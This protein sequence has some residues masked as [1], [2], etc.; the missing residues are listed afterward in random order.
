MTCDVGGNTRQKSEPKHRR[1]VYSQDSGLRSHLPCT[2]TGH[3]NEDGA[4]QRRLAHQ[5]R[6][7]QRLRQSAARRCVVGVAPSGEVVQAADGR[8]RVRSEKR[9]RL[10]MHGDNMGKKARQLWPFLRATHDALTASVSH[11]FSAFF[12][13]ASWKVL[14]NTASSLE[15]GGVGRH[16]GL[17]SFRSCLTAGGRCFTIFVGVS[18]N[19]VQVQPVGAN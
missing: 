8:R 3:A 16:W 11:P 19:F 6:C 1:T 2:H 15:N 14:R 17:R 5:R 9:A 7:M 4:L 10:C 12:A 18:Q 13:C